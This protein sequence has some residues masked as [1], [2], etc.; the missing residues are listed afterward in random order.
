MPGAQAAVRDWTDAEGGGDGLRGLDGSAQH[1]RVDH[2]RPVDRQVAGEL[3][4][5]L[6]CLVLAPVGQALAAVRTAHETLDLVHRL[7]VPYEDEP[8]PHR[9]IM[10]AVLTECQSSVR[11]VEKSTAWVSSASS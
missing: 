2:Q 3:A 9:T 4:G 5:Q 6:V 7:A 10:P 11:P 1:G 8:C